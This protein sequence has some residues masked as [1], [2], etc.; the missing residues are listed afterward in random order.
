MD[1]KKVARRSVTIALGTVCI[2]LFASLIGAFV[3]FMS[4]NTRSSQKSRNDPENWFEGDYYFNL[5][6]N[7]NINFTIP[8]AGFSSVT[9]TIDAVSAGLAGNGFQVFTGFIIS[10]TTVD[11]Q[12]YDAQSYAQIV[13]YPAV[14]IGYVFPPW[15]YF[16]GFSHWPASFKQTFDVTFSKI[17][18]WIWNNSTAFSASPP[19]WGNV[20]YYL[21]T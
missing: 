9:I 8:T 4:T 13:P 3:F 21:T 17:M 15:S 19:L 2:I 18:L 20:Y 12:V 14:P 7:Q 10:N 11:Y 6:S 16:S 5:T 1:E